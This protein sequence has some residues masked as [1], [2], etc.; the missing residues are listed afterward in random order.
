M[1]LFFLDS[2]DVLWWIRGRGREFRP[3]VENRVGEIQTAT[4]P[5]QWQHVPSDQN[6]AD[7]CTREASKPSPVNILYGGMVRCGY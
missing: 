5:W 2:K 7:L 1:V 3:F 6:P 4:E